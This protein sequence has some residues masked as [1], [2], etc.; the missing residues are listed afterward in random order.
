MVNPPQCH[1]PSYAYDY[2]ELATS[3]AYTVLTMIIVGLLTITMIIGKKTATTQCDGTSQN[4]ARWRVCSQSER[5][6]HVIHAFVCQ[7]L[8]RIKLVKTESLFY[9]RTIGRHFPLLHPA[10]LVCVWVSMYDIKAMVSS[11]MSQNKG[12][13]LLFR[14]PWRRK[15]VLAKETQIF[16]RESREATRLTVCVCVYLLP[17]LSSALIKHD[18]VR[19]SCHVPFL[20]QNGTLSNDAVWPAGRPF[21]ASSAHH[22]ATLKLPLNLQEM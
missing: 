22:F 16:A 1:L 21:D 3:N 19:S 11:N 9:V 12:R 7:H 17:G 14:A 5:T 13:T 15:K 6:F 18:H 20:P 4:W 8:V 10:V 2:D